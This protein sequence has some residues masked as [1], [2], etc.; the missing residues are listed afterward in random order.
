LPGKSQGIFLNKPAVGALPPARRAWPTAS[1]LRFR[2]YR[3]G[4][5]LPA[6]K[7]P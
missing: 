5:G 3:R 6:I 2:P 4:L 1:H 7:T